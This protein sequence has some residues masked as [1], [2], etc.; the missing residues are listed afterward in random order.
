MTKVYNLSSYER[1]S[2]KAIAVIDVSWV[3]DK[4]YE[5]NRINTPQLYRG[6]GVASRLLKQVL[7]RADHHGLTLRLVIKPSGSLDYDQLEAWYER[8]GFVKQDSGWYLRYPQISE[9]SLS[10]HFKGSK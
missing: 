8:H 9:T 6:G 10:T 1:L 7:E 3:E 2:T 4:I 5:I